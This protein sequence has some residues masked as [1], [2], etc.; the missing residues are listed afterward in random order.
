MTIWGWAW[1]KHIAFWINCAPYPPYYKKWHY[2]RAYKRHWD[3]YWKVTPHMILNLRVQLHAWESIHGTHD[4]YPCIH[5]QL[6]IQ[7]FPEIGGWHLGPTATT[8]IHFLPT[9][10]HY[11]EGVQPWLAGGHIIACGP[12]GAAWGKVAA[13]VPQKNPRMVRPG[14]GEGKSRL[15][16]KLVPHEIVSICPIKPVFLRRL[17]TFVATIQWEKE[18]TGCTSYLESTSLPWYTPQFPMF[19]QK[20]STGREYIYGRYIMASTAEALKVLPTWPYSM[21]D[22]KCGSLINETPWD[23]THSGQAQQNN[24]TQQLTWWGSLFNMYGCQPQ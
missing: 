12:H 5:R 4:P 11:V 10:K 16:G 22:I 2:Q 18:P 19:A 23:R 6:Q 1:E 7:M 20:N 13:S 3:G 15:V 24:T 14:R 8:F 17:L 21:L 9:K